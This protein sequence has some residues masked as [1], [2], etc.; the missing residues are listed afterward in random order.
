MKLLRPLSK[1]TMKLKRR[2]IRAIRKMLKETAQRTVAYAVEGATHPQDPQTPPAATDYHAQAADVSVILAEEGYADHLAQILNETDRK[3]E[4]IHR[5]LRVAAEFLVWSHSAVTGRDL[6]G[7]DVMAWVNKVITTEYRLVPKFAKHLAD[8]RHSKSATIK[9]YVLLVRKF[10]KWYVLYCS[11]AADLDSSALARFNDVSSA[12]IAT[13]KRR[14]KAERAG[15][16]MASKVRDRRMPAGGL[17]QL[18]AAVDAKLDWAKNLCN[19]RASKEEYKTFMSLLYAALYVYSVQGRQSG[20]MD[21]KYK[22]AAELLRNGYSN[23][24][25]FKTAAKWKYQPVTLSTTTSFLLK[26]YQEFLRPQVCLTGTACGDQPLWLTFEGTAERHLGVRVTQFFR[27][28]LRLHITCTA[29]RSLV[30]TAMHASYKQ[31][32]ITQQEMYSVQAINGHSSQVTEDYYIQEDRAQDVAQARSAFQRCM[33]Q[34]QD[35]YHEEPSVVYA[36]SDAA[37]GDDPPARDSPAQLDTPAPQPPVPQPQAPAVLPAST[38][39]VLVPAAFPQWPIN[40]AASATDWGGEHPH[41]GIDGAKAPWTEAEVRY[42]GQWCDQQL[43]ASG[44]HS[45]NLVAR[46]WRHIGSDPAAVAIFHPHHVLDNARLRHG[47]RKYEQL[48][49]SGAWQMAP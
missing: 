29:I 9:N 5:A 41:Y 33:G 18:Q 40:D 12:V 13:L 6:A 28:S 10:F 17:Q 27:Q 19:K 14:E 46:C 15:V 48:K 38:H 20:V 24:T 3:G 26:A 2:S 1:K 35:A 4:N 22:Q 23:S 11:H 34:S 30:E 31:G 21:M 42:I 45:H 7:D 25:K 37:D 36:S 32:R 39:P 16:T 43:A 8:H 49:A 47:Y 44:G